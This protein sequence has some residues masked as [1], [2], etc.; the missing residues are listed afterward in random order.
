[1][2]KVLK[3]F[4]TCQK[5]EKQY[6]NSIKYREGTPVFLVVLTFEWS[7]EEEDYHYELL[8]VSKN[9]LLLLEF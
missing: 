1:M 2:K 8:Y 7:Y 5:Y 9:F 4:E 3:K 6:F